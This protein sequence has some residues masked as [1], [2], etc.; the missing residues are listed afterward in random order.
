MSGFTHLHLHTEY[1]L[2]DG[3]CRIDKVI[4][5]AKAMGQTSLAITDHGNMYGV[6]EFYKQAKKKGVKP[7]IGCEVY[8]AARKMSDKV[9]TLDS[10]NSHLILLCENNEGYQNLTALVSR[11]WTEGFYIKPRVDFETLQKY[12]GGLICLSACLVG[13]LPKALLRRDYSA[14]KEIALRYNEAFGQGNY[15]IE[16]QDHSLKEQRMILPELIRL[17]EETGIPLVATNDT[18]Y[19]K[20][21]DER[22][23][24]AL[25]CIQTNH[26][27]GEATG[28]DFN[29]DEFYLKSEE[30]MRRLFDY[31][32]Q[33]IDNTQL[34]A[35]R[36]NVELEFGKIKLPRFETPNGENHFDYFSRMCRSGF[37][38]KYPDNPPKEYTDRLNYELN[39]IN[40]MG[41]V[42]YFLIVY[43]FIRYAKSVGIPV[44][45]GR[46][47]G[48][49][50][51]CAYCIGITGIDPMKYGLLFE[52]FL[53]P[54]RVTMPDFDIDFCYERRGEV[55]DYVINKYGAEY[56]AQIVTFGT[57][58][59]RA[60]VRDVGRALGMSYS[61]VDAIAKLVPRE[62]NITLSSAL[63]RSKELRKS[64]EED[65]SVREL[66]DMAIKVEGMPRHA[67]THA[68]GVVITDKPVS[69]YV[70]LATNDDCVVTQ[71]TMTALEELGLLK[72]DF[73][74]LRT[75]TVINDA[76]SMIGKREP[77]FDI[78]KISLDDKATFDMVSRGHTDGMFQFES[79][80]MRSVLQGL[81]PTTLED[82]IAVI[83]LYRPG[84]MES[85][86]D[87]IANSR[88]DKIKYKTPLLEPILNVTNGCMVYQEQVMQIFRDLA[89]YSFGRADIVR[90]AMAK[91]KHD[92]MEK[93]RH[94]FIYGMI[95][96]DGSVECEGAV[97]R[98]VPEKVANEIFDDMSSFASYA[99]NKSHAA[100]Y[101]YVAYQTAYLKRHYPCE[102]MAA[103]L[104]SVLDSSSK[105]S[106][107]I[108]ECSRIG[109]EILP[110]DVNK[111]LLKFSVENS[112]VR[113]GLLAVKNLG[114]GFINRI[115]AERE[116]NGGF[117][118]LY[119]F[120]KRLYG[121]DFNKRAIESLIK[122]GALGSLGSNRREMLINLPG[123]IEYL[124]SD[125]RRNV[126]G[127]IGF[128]DSSDNA[129]GGG[130]T[131]TIER[132]F[133]MSE[134]LYMEKEITGV[135]I[136]GHPMSKYDEISKALNTDRIS[137]L[138]ESGEEGSDDYGDNQS[139][140]LLG[141]IEKVK[142]KTTKSNATMAFIRLEDIS[143][144]IEVI[145]FPKTLEKNSVLIYEGSVVLING[146]LSVREDEDA[147]VVCEE[148][149]SAEQ[150]KN[151]A[152]ERSNA[153]KNLR[154]V[155]KSENKA[156]K[157]VGLFLRVACVN[158]E[159]LPKI[160]NLLSIFDEGGSVPIYF[161]YTDEKKYERFGQQPTVQCND[162][163][164]KELKKI[165]GENNVAFQGK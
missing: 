28:L 73:L 14:A 53:N 3:A 60:A 59:A 55:I 129:A 32:P 44:G 130:Y 165:L 78:N 153:K 98:G 17:S 34:I 36:C 9:S 13:E 99:F 5:A 37:A 132:E 152:L 112:C 119:S 92:V 68:A 7:I 49:G 151:K 139:V 29:S 89:G 103:L 145:V 150:A 25:I 108:A 74:G 8:V 87:Y 146:R 154:K 134:I 81:K 124:E 135:Y 160:K 115:I 71:Y 137:A 164:L 54:E 35:D 64:Y 2:L 110:P 156:H 23:Q 69:Q 76:Q 19:I 51:L 57:M 50:S 42:D 148:I 123:V 100:A 106:A 70:P 131:M 47:S 12:H 66:I 86:P 84:P 75:L 40:S 107:Y 102:F 10:E 45:P 6:I 46:G 33:A 143:G 101:A 120:C 149:I 58:A 15:F 117:T 72:M 1:S 11:A 155:E 82:L 88:S 161:Y 157:N 93:E 96:E 48:A 121:R 163:L 83:S 77:E 30:E 31:A 126:D 41:Y 63:K 158:D 56:V 90:R 116:A 27:V 65:E 21:E 104:T 61:S 111:S 43:D 22:V 147:K 52:R 97:K 138:L 79:G 26:T 136:S 118:S 94:N 85:I 24:R 133:P 67:S 20:K 38:E 162:A 144:D 113:F 142:T 105:I 122:C 109:I 128:F 125:K 127:Q 16:L 62:L 18:H 159:R 91:K 114:R 141:I 140:R 39:I 95:N 4:D 80:G